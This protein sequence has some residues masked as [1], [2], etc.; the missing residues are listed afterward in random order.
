MRKS[1][2]LTFLVFLALSSVLWLLIKLSG[3]YASQASFRV[4]IGNSPADQWIV[5]PEQTVKMSLNCDGFHTV[6]YKM[7][8]ESGRYVSIALDE[9]PYRLES[10]TT[11]SFSSQ[12][13][14]EKVAERIGV[15][16]SDVSV[17]DAK[18]YFNME[19]LSSKVVP[20]ELVADIKTV[21]QFDLYGIPVIDPAAVTIYGPRDALDTIRTAQTSRLAKTGVNESFSETVALD[22]GNAAVRSNTQ[23]VRVT[24]DVEKYT[25]TDWHV[26]IVAA[27]GLRVRFFPETMEVKCLVAMRDYAKLTV[28]DFRAEVDA[29]QL[30][31]LQ[32]LLDVRLVRWPK[33]VQVLNT[34]PDKVEYIIIQ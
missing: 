2:L 17:N 10:G 33:T 28:D 1:S 21:R 25:E 24:V 6:R 9:V 12:Y 16:A 7:M 26:P 19:P 32:P 14:A 3:N 30:D 13:V 23:S 8:R 20:V 15:G 34:S 18:V 27:N 31:S 29:T 4:V 5:A 22:L 11:Y